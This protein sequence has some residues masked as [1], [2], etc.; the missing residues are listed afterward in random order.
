LFIEPKSQGKFHATFDGYLQ[1]IKKNKKALFL[2]VC[3][4]KFAEGIDFTD[5][6][7]RAVILVGIPYPQYYDPK[8]I[9]KREYMTAK[10]NRKLSDIGGQQWYT[11]QASRATNQAVGRVI[12]HAEDCGIVL[13]FDERFKQN[14]IKLSRW[15]NIRK[16]VYCKFSHLE[17]D[18]N[19]FFVENQHLIKKSRERGKN[20]AEI[21]YEETG[22][23]KIIEEED[24]DGEEEVRMIMNKLKQRVNPDMNRPLTIDNYGKSAKQEDAESLLEEAE[25]T[26]NTILDI[27]MEV[28][29]VEKRK[30]EIKRF[31]FCTA[32]GGERP[33]EKPTNLKRRYKKNYGKPK[34]GE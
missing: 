31:K 18:V 3:R 8:V 7:A 4:G 11:L 10:K 1:E 20:K 13:L 5:D 21:N 17:D 24:D 30:Q 33:T 14:T 12:R 2:G 27:D 6:A 19:R 23:E 34:T 9:L 25:N 16:K 15:L 22:L 28:T 32:L 26:Y 29:P